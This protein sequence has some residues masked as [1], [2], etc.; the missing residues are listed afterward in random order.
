M[1]LECGPEP[2]LALELRPG[3]L[4]LVTGVLEFT[5]EHALLT[6]RL[7]PF[8]RARRLPGEQGEQDAIVIEEEGP[9]I[10]MDDQ[11]SLAPQV[12]FDRKGDGRIAGR[13]LAVAR[14]GT[15]VSCFR[16]ASASA[17]SRRRSGPPAASRAR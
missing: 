14:G 13:F 10:G 8:G 17:A 7:A 12:G 1:R 11:P 3:E 6:D 2:R 15:V 4:E 16:P 5:L 9:G